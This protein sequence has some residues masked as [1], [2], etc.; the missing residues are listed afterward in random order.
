MACLLTS[1][2][3]HAAQARQHEAQRETMTSIILGVAG[4]LIG[5][6]TLGNLSIWSLPAAITVAALGAYGLLFSG[7]HYERFKY[8]MA[9]M[10]AIRDEM[11]RG[12]AAPDTTPKTIAELR[13]QVER[14]HYFGFVWPKFRPTRSKPQAV[15]TSWVARQRL[16]M[17]WE[18]AH[19][20]IA[21]IGLILCLVIMVKAALPPGKEPFRVEMTKGTGK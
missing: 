5:L 9:L 10:K 21:V 6:V 15:A 11:D 7:K 3:E 19:A 12:T 16:H 4:L 2:E 17:F 18:A 14:E 1:Y 8:H 13:S 20:G